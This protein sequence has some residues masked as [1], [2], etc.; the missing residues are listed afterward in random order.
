[1]G[2]LAAITER[3]QIGSG[4]VNVFSRTPALLGMT[5]A[6]IDFVSDGRVHPRPRRVGSAGGRGLPRRALREADAAHQGDIE[7]VPK[8]WRREVLDYD[9]QT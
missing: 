9:G 7:I 4:I 6:G 3:V 8:V 2:Y 1:M 5:A